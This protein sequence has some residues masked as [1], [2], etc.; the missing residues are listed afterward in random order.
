MPDRLERT[1]EHSAGVVDANGLLGVRP[2]TSLSLNNLL[3][4]G[5]AAAARPAPGNWIDV[6][7]RGQA[8][9]FWHAVF[10]PSP[11]G[12]ICCDVLRSP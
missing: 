1:L 11:G 4:S 2:P 5:P 6:I 3:T 10:M 8:N 7:T 9:A 12:R